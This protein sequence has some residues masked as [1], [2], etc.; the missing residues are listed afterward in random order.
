MADK[1]VKT[2][3]GK[4]SPPIWLISRSS[5]KLLLVTYVLF[6]DFG[7]GS[8]GSRVSGLTLVF[9][10]LG[11]SVILL[12]FCLLRQP[13]RKKFGPKVELIFTLVLSLKI[14]IFGFY[15]RTYFGLA[16]SSLGFNDILC[17]Q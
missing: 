12:S 5:I 2:G 1:E 17:L 14:S 16:L 7:V 10:G 8:E 9:M 11:L 6:L 13:L 3:R 15:L 4:G